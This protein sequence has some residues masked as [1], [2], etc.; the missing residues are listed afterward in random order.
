MA[1]IKAATVHKLNPFKGPMT[2]ETFTQVYSGGGGDWLSPFEVSTKASTRLCQAD[3]KVLEIPG[4]VT[5]S[6][7]YQAIGY[8]RYSVSFIFCVC[9]ILFH[10]DHVLAPYGYLFYRRNQQAWRMVEWNLVHNA[11]ATLPPAGLKPSSLRT[12]FPRACR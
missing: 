3:S 12:I 11:R 5:G 6:L 9:F 7:S 2:L 4:C 8:G 1:L 10:L